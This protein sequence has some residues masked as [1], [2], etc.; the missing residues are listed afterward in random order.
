MSVSEENGP[1]NG[2]L[3]QSFTVEIPH[4]GYHTIELPEAVS[5]EHGCMFSVVL[6]MSVPSG[7]VL[8]P[9]ETGEYAASTP[10]ESWIMRDESW[11]M[12]ESCF[13]QNDGKNFC[14]QAFSVTTCDHLNQETVTKTYDDCSGQGY[15]KIICSDCNGL[16]KET[17]FPRIAHTPGDWITEKEASCT[18]TGLSVKICTVCDQ[19][20]ETEEIPMLEHTGEWKINRKATCTKEGQEVKECTVCGKRMEYR[21]IPMI[22]HNPGDWAVE[23][24]TTCTVAGILAKKCTECSLILESQDIPATGHSP[25]DWEVKVATNCWREGTLAILCQT[26]GVTLEAQK[27]PKVDHDYI[28]SVVTSP[29]CETSGVGKYTCSMCRG[30]YQVNIE[31]TGEHI[32]SEWTL[33][34]EPTATQ[35]GEKTRTCTA[36][37]K[38]ENVV[39]KA[40]GFEAK[41]GVTVDYLTGVI[42]GIKAGEV[43]LEPYFEFVDEKFTWEYENQGRLGTGTKAF[44]KNGE[45]TVGEYTILL[46]GDINGDAWYDGEDAVLANCFASGMLSKDSFGEVGYLAAD[47]NHSGSVDIGDVKLLRDAGLFLSSVDQTQT[48]EVLFETSLEYKEYL[49]IID[50]SISSEEESVSEKTENTENS[51]SIVNMVISLITELL[52][53][54]FKIRLI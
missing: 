7:S 23:R 19:T 16:L 42:S 35:D 52:S 37:S 14:I 8:V 34:K 50:Q 28:Y 25:G 2:E 11:Y 32:Y 33:V 13:S 54:L 31:P 15:E 17:L 20:V 43:S 5:L 27:I 26:C 48:A 40:T 45:E 18:Q 10:G 41:T 1:T 51:F 39:I 4:K 36:C 29:T 44:V 6:E 21:V 38:T 53:M 3:A 49:G 24:V 22:A 47:C 9:M 46:Y 30:G 12:T